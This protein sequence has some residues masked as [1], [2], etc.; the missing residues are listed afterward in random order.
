MK[1]LNDTI[2]WFGCAIFELLPLFMVHILFKFLP[3]LNLKTNNII[4]YW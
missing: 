2:L 1:G 4:K 3:R